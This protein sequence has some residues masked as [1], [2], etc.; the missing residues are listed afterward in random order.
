MFC[1]FNI[2]FALERKTI[3][4]IKTQIEINQPFDLIG[5]AFKRWQSLLGQY[6]LTF[7]KEGLSKL[8]QGECKI[9]LS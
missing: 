7:C 4:Q 3:E 1:I 9:I 2:G 6:W 5:P 8:E